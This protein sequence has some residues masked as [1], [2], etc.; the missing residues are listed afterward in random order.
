MPTQLAK[1]MPQKLMRLENMGFYTKLHD[2]LDFID[3]TT[4]VRKNQK[5]TYNSTYLIF[6][7]GVWLCA[8]TKLELWNHLVAFDLM[9][10]KVYASFKI[11]T[12]SMRTFH[13]WDCLSFG[14]DHMRE[15]L[16]TNT[17]RWPKFT[18]T[19]TKNGQFNIIKFGYS[20][21]SWVPRDFLWLTCFFSER[22]SL[23]NA[24]LPILFFFA[25]KLSFKAD[26]CL[27]YSS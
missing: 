20:Q 1:Q 23:I 25:S 11:N 26:F 21:I 8:K 13:N 6:T 18:K 12:L 24:S 22:S 14:I 19:L 7:K 17:T 9:I 2:W 15:S 16:F 4:G 5:R 3:Q 10:C 27:L